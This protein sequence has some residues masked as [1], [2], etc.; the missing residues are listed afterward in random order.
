VGRRPEVLFY[1]VFP[2]L[3]SAS[4]GAPGHPEYE[5]R[6][7]R[8]GRIDHPDYFTWYLAREAAGAVGESFGNVATWDPSMFEFP[9]LP[10]ARRALG[11]YTVPD[12]LRVLDLNDPAE[13]VERWLRADPDRG[14]Q[15][16]LHP[17]LGQSIWDERDPDDPAARRWQAVQWWSLQRPTWSIL[18]SS[19]GPTFVQVEPLTLTH[20]AV[21]DAAEALLRV[22]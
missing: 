5:H 14:A 18:A 15:P 3:A 9:F 13:V 20:P 16:G 4:A 21:R 22:L 7:Q 2:H 6:P 19:A 12:D 10:G 17:C 11:T 1:R 8:G